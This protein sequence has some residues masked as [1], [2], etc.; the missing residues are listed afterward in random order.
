MG[1]RARW[2]ELEQANHVK[3]WQRTL[4]SLTLMSKKYKVHM[5]ACMIAC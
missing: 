3:E 2:P 1:P 4:L 5:H